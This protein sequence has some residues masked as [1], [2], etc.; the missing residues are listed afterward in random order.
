MA[1]ALFRRYLSIFSYNIIAAYFCLTDVSTVTPN[2]NQQI[3]NLSL[4]SSSTTAKRRSWPENEKG[5]TALHRAARRGITQ[6]VESL[7]KDGADG[8]ARNKEND[9]PIHIACRGG[10]RQIVK[11]L[12]KHIGPQNIGIRGRNEDSLLHA[13]SEGG[14]DDVVVYL[15]KQGVN[16][17]VEMKDKFG[18][19]AIHH[20]CRNNCL[21]VVKTLLKYFSIEPDILW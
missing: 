9:T 19:T 6:E 15:L 8:T 17:L 5:E 12:L 4:D 13:A 10:H 1:L 3:S 16:V 7:L 21:Q 18:N 20:A 11:L 14:N 2:I